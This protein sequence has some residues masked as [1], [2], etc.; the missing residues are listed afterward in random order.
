MGVYDFNIISLESTAGC[1][2]LC[3]CS[4]ACLAPA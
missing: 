1:W 2:L 3:A 4:D